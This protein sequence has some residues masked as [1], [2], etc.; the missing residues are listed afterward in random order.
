MNL[1]VQ[2]NPELRNPLYWSSHFRLVDAA[3]KK[4]LVH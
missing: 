2:I 4:L 3:K 1:K